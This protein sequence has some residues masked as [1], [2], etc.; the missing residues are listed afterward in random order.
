VVGGARHH[1]V[2]EGSEVVH[3][4]QGDSEALDDSEHQGNAKKLSYNIDFFDIGMGGPQTFDVD[5]QT[6]PILHMITFLIICR[7]KIF[8][9]V[10]GEDRRPDRAVL[11]GDMAYNEVDRGHVTAVETDP[12]HVIADGIGR[13]RGG[14]RIATPMIGRR[15]NH[16]NQ[17]TSKGN[18]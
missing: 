4:V 8:V 3:A 15:K 13:G 2:Q 12:I 1:G 6:P 9:G 5:T 14:E 17:R 10:L 18:N 16:L 7:G 11:G